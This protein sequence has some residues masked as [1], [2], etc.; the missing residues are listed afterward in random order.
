MTPKQLTVEEFDERA[1]NGDNMSEYF[2][3]YQPSNLSP[4]EL[5]DEIFDGLWKDL[6]NDIHGK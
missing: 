2:T 3:D 4:E 5:L 6:E 1:S